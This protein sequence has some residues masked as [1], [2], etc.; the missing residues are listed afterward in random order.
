MEG[1]EARE[2]A[3]E[4][5]FAHDLEEEF[6]TRIARIRSLGDWANQAMAASPGKAAHYQDILHRIALCTGDDR[7]IVERVR[8]DLAAAGVFLPSQRLTN[9]L[10]QARADI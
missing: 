2:R 8:E 5:F 1:F 6:L 9:M 10:A 3:A 7:I 4:A